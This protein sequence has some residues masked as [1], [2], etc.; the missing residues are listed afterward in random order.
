MVDALAENLF[1]AWAVRVEGGE[2]LDFDDL[3]RAHPA[4]AEELRAFHDDWKLFAPLLGRVVPGLLA[5]HAG[6]VVAPLSEDDPDAREMP[7]SE[8]LERLRIHV[9]H[10]GRYRFRAVIGRGGGG[11]V[12]KVWDTKLNRPL[13]MKVVLGHGAERATN[14]SPGVDGRALARFVDEARIASQLNHPGIVPVHEL[15]ADE[16]GRAFFTMKLVKGEDLALVFEHVETGQDGWNRTRALGVLLRVCEAMSYAHAKQVIHR[17][18]KPANVMVG[19]YGEVYV[20]DW[21]LARVVGEKDLHDLRIRP[22]AHSPAA[23]VDSVRHPDG[24]SAPHSPLMTMDGTVVGTPAY[25][26]PEQARGEI[27]K[28]SA[29]SD[30]YSV[31]SMLYHLLARQSPYANPTERA[32]IQTVLAR[33]LQGPPAPLA[34]LRNDVPAELAAICEKAMARESEQRYADMHELAEDLRAY[35]EHRVVR[36]YQTGAIVEFR[37]WVGRHKELAL[38]SAAGVLVALGGLLWVSLVQTRA[39]REIGAGSSRCARWHSRMRRRPRSPSTR[40]ARCCSPARRRACRWR[41]AC[42]CLRP[43]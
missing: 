41:R 40:C 37:K 18:L 14:D 43:S 22:P 28:L 32:T 26:S 11:V 20:M 4:Q 33:V 8:L 3:L 17:D 42:N 1:A 7:S 38:A 27:E 19:P 2:S 39:K 21:G 35:L 5:S 15:G 30:V 9:P 25:M 12:L 10:S 23:T 29:R 24:D 36:A 34:S 13:A 6:I 16:A 31:G